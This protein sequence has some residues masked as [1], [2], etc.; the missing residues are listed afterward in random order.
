MSIVNFFFWVMMLL[1]GTLA[2]MLIDSFSRAEKIA[3][4]ELDRLEHT[5][6]RPQH[7]YATV[8]R[9]HLHGARRFGYRVAKDVERQCSKKIDADDRR[10]PIDHLQPAT[11]RPNRA[12]FFTIAAVDERQDNSNPES[13]N[14]QD[15]LA[16]EY[17]LPHAA[18]Y[19]LAKR[20]NEKTVLADCPSCA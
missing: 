10:L 18:G 9:P 5:T 3:L 1:L 13:A 17:S 16:Y 12:C 14:E 7:S 15:T 11:S 6:G 4:A 19:D 8:R 20:Q 2:G